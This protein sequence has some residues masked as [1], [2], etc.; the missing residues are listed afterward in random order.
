MSGNTF[1]IK[2][3]I[4]SQRVKGV[5][6][7]PKRPW[8]L[9]GLHSGVVQLLDYRTGNTVDRFEEHDGPVRGV[10]F[11]IVQPMFATGGDDCR[12]KLWNYKLRRCI[13]TLI[14]HLDYVRTVQFH[15]EQPWLVSASDDQTLIIW[16][17]Q[18]RSRLSVLAGHNH[19]VMSGQF[20]PTQDLVV[21]A[22]LD[23]S[24]RLWDIGG[25]KY[26]KQDNA[27]ANDLFGNSSEVVTRCVLEGHEKGVNW[28][29]FH[30]TK[31]YIVSAADDRSIRLWRLEGDRAFEIDHL[32]GHTSN[33]SCVMYCGDNFIIS[34]SEDRTIR[35]WDTSTRNPLQQFRRDHDRFWILSVHPTQNLIA[36]GH[37]SGLLIFKLERE[38]PAMTLTNN[39]KTLL[40]IKDRVLYK[41]DFGAGQNA[42]AMCKI[43][44]KAAPSR[45]LSANTG[46]STVVIGY[47][48]EGG[49]FEQMAVPN[50]PTPNQDGDGRRGFLM[51]PVFFAANKYAG[52]DK[53]RQINVRVVGSDQVK[54]FP[55]FKNTD[56][57]FPGPQGF[58]CCR[59]EDNFAL[60]D[61]AQKAAISEIAVP[62]V[63]YVV[64]DAGFTKAALISKHHITVVTRRLK[65]VATVHET[66]RIK[67]ACFDD[68][69]QV[70]LYTTHNHL[71]YCALQSG[72]TG[73]LCTLEKTI[74]LV[75]AN[76]DVLW[77]VDRSGQVI[78]KRFDNTE[79]SFKLAL[80]Q[81]K[82]R[83]VLKLIQQQK[84]HGQALVSYLHKSGHPEIA[85][86]F[87]SDPLVKFNLALECGLM[88]DAKQAALELNSPDCWRSLAAAAMKAGDIQL[89]QLSNAKL[90][91]FTSLGI[92]CVITGNLDALHQVMAKAPDDNAKLHLS[93]LSGDALTRARLLAN[94][95]QLPLAYCTARGAGLDEL[96]EEILQKMEPAVAE[97]VQRTA[98]RPLPGVSEYDAEATNWPTLP[99]Q[100]SYFMRML[101]APGEFDIREENTAAAAKS[102]AWG[103]EDDDDIFGEKDT[104]ADGFGG[105]DVSA[106]GD[107]TTGGGAGW[108]D[109]D[110]EID[111]SMLPA[112]EKGPAV[113]GAIVPRDGDAPGKHWAEATSIVAAH[114]AGGSFHTAL[115]LLQRQIGLVNAE[116]L[117]PYFLS[118]WASCNAALP[119]TNLPAHILA[120][121]TRPPSDDMRSHH[122]PMIP[123]MLP[124]LKERVRAGY[125]LFA[126][127]KFSDLVRVFQSLAHQL[128]FVV[129]DTREEQQEV[130]EMLNIA[131]EYIS[132]ILVELYRREVTTTDPKR[133]IELAA[134]LTHFKLQPAHLSLVTNQAMMQAFKLGFKKLS[135]SLARRFLDLDPP[136]EKADKAKKIIQ[137]VA[138]AAEETKL[139]YDERNPFV[140]CV[141]T[142]KPMYRGTVEPIRCSFCSAQAHPSTKGQNC[143]VCAI[144]ALGA[145]A[146][147][148][149]NK[150][151]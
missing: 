136:A 14:G 64:W 27:F 36:A 63:K 118:I 67:S 29:A 87:A 71:K 55:P 102:G 37:D 134:Y 135:G 5:C 49:L 84:V 81:E 96:A 8:V 20:H 89:A 15:R 56:R 124:A 92:Q 30:P 54:T 103:D 112:T 130:R 122:F 23:L 48:C 125:A 144:A 17:W 31:P 45:T 75:R 91:N 148:M 128:I 50:T 120:L 77:Y 99:V 146:S 94:A 82:F 111:D 32:R 131:K 97:R 72:E 34:N 58:I 35:V 85:M 80:Q 101:K 132:A 60:Y 12:I 142:K 104:A 44:R 25:L 65:Q 86:H 90:K 73:T 62:H 1:L 28:A 95:G 10:D 2:H 19:Y 113:A 127:G 88:D 43:S 114:V 138:T 76:N 140:L 57:L 22:S 126:E 149:V 39:N 147:G 74:Y 41:Y 117:K 107:A 116:P 123:R 16:N 7:H 3:D 151:V 78:E 143:P 4:R 33:V 83:D 115:S 109:D 79:L 24:V 108:D 133:S 18:S 9:I 69:L 40:Y 53:T 66:T 61:V 145:E 42:S 46:D 106:T 6:F 100:E 70:L 26:K 93:L 13:A 139:D 129:A 141:V 59:S 121:A 119:G 105:A 98:I 68:S 52:L 11:H 51:T 38:R 110:I 150:G 137:A 21:S 47:E